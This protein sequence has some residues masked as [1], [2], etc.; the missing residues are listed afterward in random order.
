M[1]PLLVIVAL[2]SFGSALVLP[3]RVS[4]LPAA[5]VHLAL[6]MGAMPLIFGA[7][8]HFIPVLTRSGAPAKVLAFLP[9]AALGAGGMA[10][11]A[12]V[13]GDLLSPWLHAAAGLGLVAAS[14]LAAWEM[15]RG[16][17]MLGDPHP[18]LHWYVAA[19]A[20]LALALLAVAAMP[21]WP[22]ERL[23]LKRF[24]LHL[25]LLGF[26]GLTALG[27]VQVLLPTAAGR[28]DPKAALRLRRGLPWALAGVVLTAAGAA[29]WP[30]LAWLGLASWA[31]ALFP[32]GRDWLVVY[33][34]ELFAWHGAVP[35]LGLAV[36]GFG[37]ALAAGAVSSA[38][39]AHL[40]VLGFLFPLA[41]G[42][43]GQLLPLWLRPGRQ[44]EWH[45]GV[46]ARL[47]RWA[48]ARGLL[49]LAAGL[50]VL[51]G[52]REGFLFAVAGLLHFAV[53]AAGAVA[54]RACTQ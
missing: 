47:T 2:L 18:C 26:I 21:L 36:L 34:K 22:A 13:R 52:G 38:G 44:T 43:A 51:C 7:M 40:F 50:V 3:W 31:G 30:P 10:V 29:W 35:S 48:G 11:Y 1:L 4:L 6:A 54:N 42:A 41:T 24:H 33:R 19:L 9:L 53:A 49:F 46:R 37:L 28:F 5:H 17:A 25:N 20:C 16:R 12:F 39:A 23:A 27:T 8:L 14:F 15:K 45:E 32:L